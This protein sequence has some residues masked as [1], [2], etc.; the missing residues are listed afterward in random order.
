VPYPLSA[1]ERRAAHPAGRPRAAKGYGAL[2]LP[3]HS[4]PRHELDQSSLQGPTHGALALIQEID[5][6]RI[7]PGPR[8]LDARR[9]ILLAED[10]LRLARVVQSALELEGEAQWSVT[11]ANDGARALELAAASPPQVVLLDVFLPGVDGVEVYKR[12]RADPATRATRVIFVSAATSLDLYE[13]GIQDGVL[14]RKPFDVCDLVGLVR[15][16][17]T[18]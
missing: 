6:S 5:E 15:A 14:M 11:V 18:A 16:L 7:F 17:L 3:W 13:R 12:L 8:P 9:S 4:S 2:V 1:F 10:D